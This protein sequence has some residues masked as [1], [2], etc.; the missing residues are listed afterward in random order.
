MVLGHSMLFLF[1]NWLVE[2]SNL[3]QSLRGLVPL[4]QH[5]QLLLGLKAMDSEDLSTWMVLLSR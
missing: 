1:E 4:F 5:S 3:M 2:S